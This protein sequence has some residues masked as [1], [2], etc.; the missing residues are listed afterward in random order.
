MWL[1]NQYQWNPITNNNGI[2][3][4]RHINWFSIKNI[5]C[6]NKGLLTGSLTFIHKTLSYAINMVA[7][8]IYTPNI[9]ICYGGCKHLYTKHYHML[10]WLQALIH[11]TI[12]FDKV[13]EKGEICMRLGTRW[14]MTIYKNQ[15][16]L[17]RFQRKRFWG[18][19][20]E[21]VQW[22]YPICHNFSKYLSESKLLK[23]PL[24]KY[25]PTILYTWKYTSVCHI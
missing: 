1:L 9:I 15:V 10:W 8:S 21:S 6:S 22:M 11:K 13:I 20:I 7:A 3:L 2:T 17:W 16:V 14:N 12:C 25:I 5:Y 18:G 23:S 24:T 4:N 19:K